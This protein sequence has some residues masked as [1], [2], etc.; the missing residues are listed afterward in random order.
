MG[1]TRSIYR[2]ADDGT[3]CHDDRLDQNDLH[4][5][6]RHQSCGIGFRAERMFGQDDS[7]HGDYFILQRSIH[8]IVLRQRKHF[9][10]PNRSIGKLFFRR[11]RFG[12]KAKYF[13][14]KNR[15]DKQKPAR[16]ERKSTEERNETRETSHIH[17][18]TYHFCHNVIPAYPALWRNVG[19]T[20]DKNI[21][22]E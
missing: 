3:L 19:R 16:T 11:P 18:D 22:Q 7:A 1:E 8:L 10:A 15:R 6:T 14:K 21:N 13:C 12:I 4:T 2:T 9:D 20:V 5:T 17:S